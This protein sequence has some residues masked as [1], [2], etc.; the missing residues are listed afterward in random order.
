MPKMM[1]Q[2][3]AEEAVVVVK[4]LTEEDMATYLRIK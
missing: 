1:S 4:Q 2:G 3:S